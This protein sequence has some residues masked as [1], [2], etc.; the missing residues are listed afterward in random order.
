MRDEIA[1]Q[2]AAFFGLPLDTRQRHHVCADI[3][4]NLRE[5]TAAN[6][7]TCFRHHCLNAIKLPAAL[8]DEKLFAALSRA[9]CLSADGMGIVWASRLMGIRVSERVTGIDLMTDLLAL[10]ARD[11]VRVFLLGARQ[12][13]LDQLTISLPDR[14]PGLNIVGTHHG[15]EMDDN[16]L[17]SSVTACKPDALF[18]ALPSPR[19]ELFVDQYA[20]ETGCRFVMGVGGAFDVLAGQV[21]R[22]PLIWQRI[23]LEFLWRIV[24]QPHYMV[25]RYGRGLVAFS[26][27]VLPK[28]AS[29][30]IARLRGAIQRTACI[31]AVIMML[32]PL[33]VAD[34]RAQSDIGANFDPANR[35]AALSWLESELAELSDPEDVGQMIEV[36]VGALLIA[37]GAED[38][39]AI[40]WQASEESVNALLSL[41]EAV[42]G[43]GTKRFLAVTVLG[44]VLLRL[45]DLH[46]EPGQFRQNMRTNAPGL[47]TRLFE[48]PTDRQLTFTDT[49]ASVSATFDG[50]T[51]RR[52]GQSRRQS[53]AERTRK[54]A[55]LLVIGLQLQGSTDNLWEGDD[56]EDQ[57]DLAEL[58][59]ASPR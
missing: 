44:G 39:N 15:Y 11:G 9:S 4:M 30:Q 6:I 57:S 50:D 13:V 59:D 18:V 34:L 5:A 41:F 25:P 24:C 22:A 20:P 38:S 23:G 49:Q 56:Y 33:P 48:R 46:P 16:K 10:F 47:M 32:L 58:E 14:F 43:G 52:V 2:R 37:D 3:R 26:R 53:E 29:F 55:P 19:K 28:I 36:L 7:R 35:Q 12:E 17:A 8:R 54:Y 42:L 51:T 40:D 1:G 31:L 21:R 27:V 45:I